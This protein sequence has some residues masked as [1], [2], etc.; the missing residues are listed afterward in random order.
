MEFLV[1]LP[2]IELLQKFFCHGAFSSKSKNNQAHVSCSRN[3]KPVVWAD[4][5][6]KLLC[7]SY[8]FSDHFLKARYSIIPENK[9]KFECSKSFTQGD[10]PVLMRFLKNWGKNLKFIETYHIINGKSCILVLKIQWLN[11]ESSVK[12]PTIF[13]PANNNR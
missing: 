11:V 9:P 4:Q 5:S 1:C 8:I 2:L 3:F 7:K 13:Y 6:L 12:W 10:L